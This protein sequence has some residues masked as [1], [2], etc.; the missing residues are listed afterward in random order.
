MTRRIRKRKSS[1]YSSNKKGRRSSNKKGRRSNNKKGRRSSN[2]K[3]RRSSRR[4]SRRSGGAIT[5]L[6]VKYGNTLI[7]DGAD[8]T[9]Q[10]QVYNNLPLITIQPADT[11]TYLVTLTDPDAPKENNVGKQTWTHYVALIQPDG[12]VLQEYYKYQPPSPPAN[13]G[14]HRYIFNVYPGEEMAELHNAKKLSGAIYYK[15]VLEPIINNKKLLN[16]LGYKVN[17]TERAH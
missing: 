6:I 15:Q 4:S 14:T 12:T 3:G 9:G 8:L 16:T 11:K 2:K 10:P 1:K 7:K 17:S 5:Q 13:S